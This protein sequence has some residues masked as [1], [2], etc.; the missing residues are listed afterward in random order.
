L[1]V[2]Y[3]SHVWPA[4]L[5]R[6]VQPPVHG[7]AVVVVVVLDVELVDVDVEDVELVVTGAS[8]VVIGGASVVVSVGIS[9]PL[10]AA[11]S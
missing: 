4:A 2:P 10:L 6:Q 7:A 11:A 8:V 3:F 9:H 5:H 1:P